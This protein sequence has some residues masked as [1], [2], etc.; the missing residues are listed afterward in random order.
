MFETLTDISRTI[1]SKV[2]ALVEAQSLVFIL[3]TAEKALSLAQELTGV[4]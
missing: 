2:T 4:A 3:E 1:S